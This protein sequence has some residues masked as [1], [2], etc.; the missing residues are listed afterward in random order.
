[1]ELMEEP[2]I[3]QPTKPDTTE[4]VEQLKVG[5]DGKPTGVEM[6][7]VPKDQ[8]LLK[9]ELA[10]H[11]MD[12]KVWMEETRAWKMNRVRLYAL[13]LMHC[14]PDLEEVLKTMGTW[15]TVSDAQDAIGLLGMVRDAAHDQTEAKQTTMGYVEAIADLF[16]YHQEVGDSD[17]DYSIM[18]NAMVEAIKAHK[19][20]PWRHPG[21]V[22]RHM[23]RIAK[24]LLDQEPDRTTVSTTRKT[25]IYE[26]AQ[27]E[28]NEAASSSRA[29]SSWARTTRGTRA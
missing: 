14:P 11:M 10:I 1:M 3:T 25:E 22:G 4:E 26:Q 19:G 21:L 28:G 7:K 29:S 9:M 20:C 23:D 17:D 27:K 12:Y 6:V 2:V 24:E 8:E 13:I 15:R 5:A 18:F 16:T